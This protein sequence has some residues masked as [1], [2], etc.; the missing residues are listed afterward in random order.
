MKGYKAKSHYLC[1]RKWVKD[2]VKEKKPNDVKNKFNDN[3]LG[4]LS[5]FYMN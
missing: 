1:I 3:Q 2:A 5:K 4:N